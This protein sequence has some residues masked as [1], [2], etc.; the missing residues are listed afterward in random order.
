VPSKVRGVV[1]VGKSKTGARFAGLFTDSGDAF[2]DICAGVRLSLARH[3]RVSG[4]VRADGE[5]AAMKATR[6]LPGHRT[7]VVILQV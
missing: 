5:A 6:V 3:N 7:N 1:P 2:G 4:A